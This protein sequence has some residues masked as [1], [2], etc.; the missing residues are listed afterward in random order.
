MQSAEEAEGDAGLGAQEESDLKA[1]VGH[2]WVQRR[3]AMQ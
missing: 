1:T 2:Q 3:E